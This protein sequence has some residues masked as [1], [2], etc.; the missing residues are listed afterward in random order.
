MWR[1]VQRRA[2]IRWVNVGESTRAGVGS[3]L[4]VV[5]GV[6]EYGGSCMM[7]VLEGLGCWEPKGCVGG[8]KDILCGV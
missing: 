3:G 7:P 2:W 8:R 6:W 5:K 4:G 1:D